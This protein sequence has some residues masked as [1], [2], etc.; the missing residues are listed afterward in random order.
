MSL[1]WHEHFVITTSWNEWPLLQPPA[2]RDVRNP[3]QHCFEMFNFSASGH[4]LN[5]VAT[6]TRPGY[7]ARV[8]TGY[9]DTTGSCIELYFK[10][11]SSS[12]ADVSTVSVIAISEDKYETVLVSSGMIA[13]SSTWYRLYAVLP[14]GTY[15]IAI[16]GRRSTTGLSSLSI[17]DVAIQACSKFGNVLFLNYEGL[18]THHVRRN[19]I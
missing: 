15:Q 5:M 7:T 19:D 13:S 17:D 10:T 9:V 3:W 2:C 18:L 8:L 11:T 12:T 16:E 4:Y 1:S 6:N 14:N